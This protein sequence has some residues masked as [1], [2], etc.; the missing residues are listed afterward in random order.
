MN[1]LGVKKNHKLQQMLGVKMSNIGFHVGVK[2]SPI[3]SARSEMIPHT[4][5]RDI[6]NHSKDQT[7]LPLGITKEVKQKVNTLERRR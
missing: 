3:S 6:Y 5:L 2:H 4:G 1:S 7:W